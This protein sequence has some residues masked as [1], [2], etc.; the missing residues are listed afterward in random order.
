MDWGAII[1]LSLAILGAGL[2][3]GGIVA[4][5]GSTRTGLR[6]FSAGSVAAGAV[7]LAVVLFTLPVSSSGD[8]SPDPTVTKV[9]VAAD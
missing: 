1:Q 9:E 3:V 5:R 4:Y 8:G 7:M 2:I 6:A